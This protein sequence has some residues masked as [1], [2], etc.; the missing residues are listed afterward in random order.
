V[1]QRLELGRFDHAPGQPDPRQRTVG[2][3]V[4]VKRAG[5]G[6]LVTGARHQLTVRVALHTVGVVNYACVNMRRTLPFQLSEARRI[7]APDIGAVGAIEMTTLDTETGAESQ[8]IDIDSAPAPTVE[9][10]ADTAALITEQQVLFSSAATLAPGKTRGWSNPVPAAAV[11]VRAMFTR[12]EKPRARRHYPQRFG[13]IE[14]A[15]MSRAMD[16]L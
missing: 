3:S 4:H 11:A 15:A 5:A 1:G 9:Q 16:R 14:N 13:Y 10:T 12:P 6:V 8:A 2:G 7:R